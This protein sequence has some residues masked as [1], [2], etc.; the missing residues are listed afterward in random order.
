[1][2]QLSGQLMQRMNIAQLQVVVNDLHTQIEGQILRSHVLRPSTAGSYCTQFLLAQLMH[3]HFRHT[4]AATNQLSAI[5]QSNSIQ[6]TTNLQAQGRQFYISQSVTVYQV[7][8]I[9]QYLSLSGYQ[10]LLQQSQEVYQVLEFS[11]IFLTHDP[12]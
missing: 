7:S 1:M 3:G 2:R 6:P 11:E 9:Y 10:V 12:T 8:L 4:L 5:T